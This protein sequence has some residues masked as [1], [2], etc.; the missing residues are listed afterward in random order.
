MT[1][2]RRTAPWWRAWYVLA[3]AVCA[4]AGAVLLLADKAG[5]AGPAW[6]G[7]APAAPA[8]LAGVAACLHAARAPHTDRRARVFWRTSA[9]AVALV[10]VG[11]ASRVLSVAL[12]GADPL[13]PDALPIACYTAAVLTELC[14]L[15]RVPGRI[16]IT[17]RQRQ[18]FLLDAAIVVLCAGLFAYY[19]SFRHT[20]LWDKVGGGGAAMA[21]ILLACLAVLVIGKLALQGVTA[22]DTRALHW[23]AASIV[24]GTAIGTAIPHAAH[25]ADTLA[26]VC[27]TLVGLGFSLGARSQRR[28][29]APRLG[30][31][32]TRTRAARLVL[33]LPYAAV[34]AT[35]ALLIGVAAAHGYETLAVATGAVGLTMIVVYR[36]VHAL[37]DNT[38]LL[39]RVDAT[40]QQ[41][42]DAQSQLVHQATHDAVTGLGNRR[43]FVQALQRCLESAEP[44]SVALIDLDDFKAVNDRL[45]HGIGDQLL[46]H[47]A[48]LLRGCVRPGDTVARLGGD[49]FALLLPGMSAAHGAALL[50]RVTEA[51]QRPFHVDGHA[52]LVQA[53]AGLAATA[54]GIDP[55][56]TLR[57]ADL[58][59]YAAKEA[60]KARYATYDAELDVRANREARL[61]ADLREALAADEFTLHFQPVVRLS[62]RRVVGAEALVRWAHPTRGTVRPDHFIPVAERTGTIVPLGA[63][64]L[65]RACQEAVRWLGDPM[66]TSCVMGVNISARQLRE[67][68]FAA[69]VARTLADTGL[70][71][72]YLMVE[73]TE[74]AVFD[75]VLASGALREISA[76][77]V[78]IALDDFGTGHS[79]LGLLRTI[80]VD[81]LKL[82]RSFVDRITE[83]AT[84]STIAAAM[85]H[86]ADGLTLDVVAEGVETAAQAARLRELGYELCQGYHFAPPVPAEQARAMLRDGLPA[87]APA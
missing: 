10:A 6:L 16:R 42:R 83:N 25:A 75:N 86:L 72:E 26:T 81:V 36:Q 32:G 13:R 56:E 85:R 1:V 43:L 49:E 2:V 55:T 57:R 8:A 51:L 19:L 64:I 31:S 80:P 39:H 70:P 78:Q 23:L 69:L 30:R 52:L 50:D 14:A 3:A 4:L 28:L 20:T 9:A 76:L 22:V 58:A 35:D 54:A 60:G 24:V 59:M 44:A 17:A 82:D 66:L 11:A 33:L 61:G 84:E 67:P 34:A 38:L 65:R 77:G 5:F 74:T 37:R 87:A 48:G 40:V 7:A 73:V 21:T 68:G 18:R 45:G 12:A 15:L 79:S 63:W 47:V 41:L 71:P 62:D 27:I 46:R 53:S 29:R